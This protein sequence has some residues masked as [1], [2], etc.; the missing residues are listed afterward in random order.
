MSDLMLDEMNRLYASQVPSDFEKSVAN[1][2]FAWSMLQDE[3]FED[4]KDLINAFW[5]EKLK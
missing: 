2:I 3:V 1:E 5:K 4:K